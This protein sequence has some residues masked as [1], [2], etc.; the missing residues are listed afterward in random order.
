MDTSSAERL[1]REHEQLFHELR[2]IIP[3][4]EV[5]FA[6]LL[7]VAFSE[8]FEIL[9]TAQQGIF[10]ATFLC[11]GL[12][13]VLLLAPAAFH[14]VRFRQG[15]KEAMMRAAN[16]EAIAAL[17]LLSAAMSGSVFLITDILYGRWAAYT[18]SSALFVV[19]CALWWGHPLSRNGCRETSP[20][21]MVTR[22][23]WQRSREVVPRRFIAR[24]ERKLTQ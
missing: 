15:D 16:V 12:S 20:R 22:R 7:T 6:F 4:V 14:R 9:T 18:A 10:F 13:L 19:A 11:S 5:L 17:A 23:K 21:R 8:R 24:Q 1:E 2:A 3:G